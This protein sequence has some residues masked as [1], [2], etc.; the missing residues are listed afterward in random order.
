VEFLAAADGLVQIV[1]GN[2][3]QPNGRK[4]GV[5]TAR[6]AD[7]GDRWSA[8]GRVHAKIL[9][10]AHLY[11]RWCPAG[12]FLIEIP[13]RGSVGDGEVNPTNLSGHVRQSSARARLL[14]DS[15]PDCD[16]DDTEKGSGAAED[17]PL[18]VVGRL[19][20]VHHEARHALRY[21]HG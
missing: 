6:V 9:I 14:T 17:G 12:H 7:T 13:Q 11:G 3:D 4:A 10:A 19:A 18:Q 21:G 16:P 20:K 15:E 8:G 2:V 5:V 1:H